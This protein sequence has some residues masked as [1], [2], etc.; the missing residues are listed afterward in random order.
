MKNTALAAVLFIS[1]APHGGM[2]PVLSLPIIYDL[3]CASSEPASLLWMALQPPRGFESLEPGMTK[4]APHHA[5]GLPEFDHAHG[6]F[7]FC[8]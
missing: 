1:Q 8:G 7:G 3:V 4:P 5:G 2:E 6:V